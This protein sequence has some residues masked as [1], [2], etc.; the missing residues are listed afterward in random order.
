MNEFL[1]KLRDSQDLFFKG[2]VILFALG[3][4]VFLMPKEGK[5][6]YEFQKG[7]PW[8]HENLYAPYDFAI[9]KSDAEL[10]KEEQAI[11]NNSSLYFVL[12]KTVE[13]KALYN[14]NTSLLAQLDTLKVREHK[15]YIEIVSLAIKLLNNVYSQ[16]IIQPIEN[17]ELKNDDLITLISVN[18]TIEGEKGSFMTVKLASE[19]LRNELQKLKQGSRGILQNLI[20]DNLHHNVLYDETTSEKVLND[21]LSKL[22]KTKGKVE[23]EQLIVGKGQVVNDELWLQLQS[24][25]IEYEIKKGSEKNFYFITAGQVLI[26]GMVFLV[27]VLFLSLFRQKIINVNN[28]VMFIVVSFTLTVLMGM[29][30]LYFEQVPIYALPFCI[31]PILIKSFYDELL[32]SYIYFLAIILIGFYAPNGFEFVFLQVITGLIAL[33]S[34]VS[35]RKRSQLL[36]TVFII[37]LSY[38]VSNLAILI[39]QEGNW[40]NIKIENFYWFGASAILTLLVYPLIYIYEKIFGFLS[41]VTLMEIADTNS[42]L[43]RELA[44]KAPGTF[45]HSMQVANLAERAILKVGGSPLLVRTG[46]LY[47]DIGK[48][49]A[50]HYFIENQVG[51][52]N[53]HNDLEPNESAK[54]IINHVLKGIEIAKKNNLPEV[55]IDFIRSHHGTSTVKYFLYQYKTLH[56][57]KETDTGDF[58]YPGP[59][60]FSKET[61]VLMMADACEAASRSLNE[62]NEESLSSLVTNIIDGQAKEG[63]F[64]NADITYKD[65]SVIKRIFINM[66]QNIYHVRIAYPKS[67]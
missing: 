39:V 23:K 66:L 5:F 40:Q 34:L 42:P 18:E 65:I 61:A 15:K 60:P 29:I 58:T 51:G 8:L 44:A 46:A 64:A 19:Y 14:L 37:F 32:A 9:I 2:F 12:D 49:L 4:I 13:E 56:P 6:K 53:P 24:L 52:V 36:T 22:S 41:D 16:G 1:N 48:M 45:Q 26:V 55:I 38:S 47:H 57:E 27:M 7:K 10:I 17:R 11:R 50:P 25:K 20:L 54:I 35:L 33:F 62:Y 3:I 67:T 63:Q 28:R 21:R 31:L 59:I 43:L 30:P